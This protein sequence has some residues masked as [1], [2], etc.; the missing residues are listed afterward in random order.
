MITV[1]T[2]EEYLAN[3]GN[4]DSSHS[5]D[6]SAHNRWKNIWSKR[7]SMFFICEGVYCYW[8]PYFDDGF[9]NT[10]D[11]MHRRVIKTLLLQYLILEPYLD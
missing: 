7:N 5:F 4:M 3:N 10:D 1:I 2:K 11:V 8:S 6:I 9:M